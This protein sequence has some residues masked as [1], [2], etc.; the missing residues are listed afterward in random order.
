MLR[1]FQSEEISEYGSLGPVRI[2]RLIKFLN[3][4]DNV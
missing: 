2:D 4:A 3:L 1:M